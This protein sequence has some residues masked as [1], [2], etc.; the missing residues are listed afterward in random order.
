[1]SV[2]R[3]TVIWFEVQ[4]C[5]SCCVAVAPRIG[6]LVNEAKLIEILV[7]RTRVPGY[8]SG[9]FEFAN[10]TGTSRTHK[11]AVMGTALS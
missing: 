5:E 2:G 1:M 7:P 9:V 11:S 10:P 8:M 6:P 3:E 4:E